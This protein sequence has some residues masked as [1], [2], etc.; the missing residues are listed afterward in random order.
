[1]E[2]PPPK[3]SG[4]TSDRVVGVDATLDAIVGTDAEFVLHVVNPGPE[5]IELTFRSGQIAEITVYDV[6][7]GE[8]VWRWSNDGAFTQAIER[9][10][11]D[12]SGHFERE[13]TWSDPSPGKYAA[14]A[15]LEINDEVEVRTEFTV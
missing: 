15:A 6:E 10:A 14:V 3:R 5:P 8:R 2:T 7:T 11:L 1:M 13:Y 12:P 4:S 9:V